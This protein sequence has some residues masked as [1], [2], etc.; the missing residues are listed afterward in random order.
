M[1]SGCN[2]RS[3]SF[4]KVKIEVSGRTVEKYER[5]MGYG[6]LVMRCDLDGKNYTLA[7]KGEPK[8]DVRMY[9]CP[10]CGKAYLD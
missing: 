3:G 2:P 9:H 7:V 8:S 6:N 1:C 4:E 10:T 5:S